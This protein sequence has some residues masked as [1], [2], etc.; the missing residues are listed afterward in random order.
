MARDTESAKKCLSVCARDNSSKSEPILMNIFLKMSNL[1]PEAKFEDEQN[2]S[3][4][5]GDMTQKLVK[6]CQIGV[7]ERF[8]EKMRE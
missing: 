4:G 3:S 5:S 1:I 2:R 6:K 8:F 7:H